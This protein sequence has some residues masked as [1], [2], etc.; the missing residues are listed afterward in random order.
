MFL[1]QMLQYSKYSNPE[2]VVRDV[3][4][5][6]QAL[7]IEDIE[8][9][10]FRHANV[11]VYIIAKL[12]MPVAMSV[13]SV[14]ALSKYH[15]VLT[16]KVINPSDRQNFVGITMAS[17]YIFLYIVSVDA[18]AITYYVANKTEYGPYPKIAHSI[19]LQLTYIT[20]ILE[21][22]L[23]IFA[24]IGVVLCHQ[25]KSRYEHKWNKHSFVTVMV[26]LLMT[27]Y[28]PFILF[29]TLGTTT[30]TITITSF[31]VV[32]LLCSCI[33]CIIVYLKMPIDFYLVWFIV[34]PIVFVSS[35]IDYIMVAWLTEPAKTTSVSILASALMFYLFSLTRF[36]YSFFTGILNS[37]YL[38]LLL[39]FLFGL[40]GVGMIAL[41]IAAFYL[42]P[43]PSIKLADYLDNFFQISLVILAGLITYKVISGQESDLMKFFKKFSNTYE[44]NNGNKRKAIISKPVPISAEIIAAIK[45]E[46]KTIVASKEDTILVVTIPQ[47][48][49]SK[50][51]VISLSHVHLEARSQK[52]DRNQR[53][54]FLET[55]RIFFK[56]FSTSNIRVYDCSTDLK[57]SEISIR[58]TVSTNTNNNKKYSVMNLECFVSNDNENSFELYK[59]SLYHD[60]CDI[61]STEGKRVL[62]HTP[63]QCYIVSDEFPSLGK[64]ASC[65]F[66]NSVSMHTD[67]E[68][69]G[70]TAMTVKNTDRILLPVEANA[71]IQNTISEQDQTISIKV[72]NS[73][74]DIRSSLNNT[75]TLTRHSRCVWLK[76]VILPD[77]NVIQIQSVTD[78]GTKYVFF[79][80][81]LHT[82]KIPLAHLQSGFVSTTLEVDSRE[83][84]SA[85]EFYNHTYCQHE[86]ISSGVHS[87]NFSGNE[88]Q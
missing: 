1:L 25:Y 51:L 50:K 48:E 19:S 78:D 35:H 10:H 23:S 69:S 63:I 84:N 60:S 46:N 59:N 6:A 32:C 11:T 86:R 56:L 47:H 74:L 55:A 3:T 37:E 70:S 49:E 40:F 57:D 67:N 28:I 16:E 62:L 34:V 2:G 33:L 53:Q 27:L 20:F 18:A 30:T 73:Q 82:L 88:V 68:G 64:G 21:C 4:S 76:S 79:K 85:L 71:Y 54:V 80:S 26:M 5:T 15:S 24:L 75:V 14:T 22:L 44:P 72:K 45:C 12:T 58:D 61:I 52:T 31:L 38:K 9:G 77:N 66:H 7:C 39:T 29:L 13:A 42:L 81:N 8:L 83:N 17:I 36:L 87:L 41:Q 43:I 65:R